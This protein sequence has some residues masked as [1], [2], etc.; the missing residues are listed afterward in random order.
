MTSTVDLF[1]KNEFK[2]MY[3]VGCLMDIPTGFYEGGKHG[4]MILIGGNAN[5]V[6][7]GG[8]ANTFKSQLSRFINFTCIARYAPALAILYDTEGN[9]TKKD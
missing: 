5:M 6:G 9:V 7:V 1:N 2:P 4:E 3:N 8:K